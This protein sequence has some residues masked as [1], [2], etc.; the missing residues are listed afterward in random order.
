MALESP[1]ASRI[2]LRL[3]GRTVTAKIAE[4]RI[5]RRRFKAEQ[6]RGR[7]WLAQDLR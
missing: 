5:D 2:Y 3:S 7:C 4:D 6:V 1:V